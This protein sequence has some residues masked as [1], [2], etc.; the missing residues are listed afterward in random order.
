M[1]I[2][3]TTKI[4]TIAFRDYHI[5]RMDDGNIQLDKELDL[6]KLTEGHWQEGDMIEVK[7]VDDRI[8]LVKVVLDKFL[9]SL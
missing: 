6:E 8:T 5:D 9:D 7:I 1:P 2:G 4:K 3:M